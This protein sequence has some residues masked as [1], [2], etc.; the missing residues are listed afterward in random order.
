MKKQNSLDHYD[1]FLIAFVA[2]Y[3]IGLSIFC[4]LWLFSKVFNE[5][6]LNLFGE[7][8]N[9]INYILS[10][11][12]F[13]GVLG[14]LLYTGR[15]MYQRL[16]SF[17]TTLETSSQSVSQS[18]N[19]KIWLYWYLYRPFQA[20]VLSVI[21]VSLFNSGFISLQNTDSLD[22]S[23]LY[24]QVALGALVGF[25]THE[26]LN[27]LEEVIK[28]LFAKT[29]KPDKIADIHPDSDSKKKVEENSD[30]QI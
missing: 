25:G 4:L 26:V 22:I 20:G 24:F 1:I 18:F 7:D 13:S 30:T 14:G 21:T 29:T 15:A 9:H 6:K 28:V 10:Y 17:F 19:I 27:K 8:T 2:I 5:I 3:N 16:G 11:F 23:S 12:F